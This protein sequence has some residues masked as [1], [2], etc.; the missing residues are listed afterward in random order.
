MSGLNEQNARVQLK[1]TTLSGDTPTIAPSTDHTDGNWNATDIYVGE[2]MINAATDAMWFRSLNGII[3]ITSGTTYIDNTA[4]VNKS[5]GTM[6]GGLITPSLSATSISATTIYSPS[7]NGTFIG[8]GSG[9]TGITSTIFTGGTISGPTTFTSDVDLCGAAVTVETL[10]GCGGTLSIISD[11]EVFG[12]ISATTF[13]G[14]AAGLTDLPSLSGITLDEVLTQGDTSANGNIQLTNGDITLDNGVFY[15]DGSGL[16]NIPSSPTPTLDAVLAAGNVSDDYDILLTNGNIVLGNGIFYG[17][18]SGL[19]NIGAASDIYVTG[20]TYDNS[21]GTA[22]FS[23]TSGGTFQVTGF[24]TGS[25]S[26]FTGYTYIQED[27][28]LQSLAL[29]GAST[30]IFDIEDFNYKNY[31]QRDSNLLNSQ[32]EDK[33]NGDTTN[34]TQG[35]G[36]GD[37]G[38]TLNSATTGGTLGNIEVT[39][40]LIETRV[41]DGTDTSIVSVQSNNINLSNESITSNFE[42]TLDVGSTGYGDGSIVSTTT[43][44]STGTFST[45]AQLTDRREYINIV[46]DGVGDVFRIQIEEQPGDV[47]SYTFKNDNTGDQYNK[48]VNSLSSSEEIGNG[49]IKDTISIDPS[50]LSLGTGIVSE[51]TSTND[52]SSIGINPTL[53][54]LKTE[55]DLEDRLIL[56]TQSDTNIVRSITIPSDA[57]TYYLE[58]SNIFQNETIITNSEYTLIETKNAIDPKHEVRITQPNI[59]DTQSFRQQFVNYIHD[60]VTD[61]VNLSYSEI[62]VESIYHNVQGGEGQQ[63]YIQINNGGV[64]LS[65]VEGSSYTDFIVNND[66]GFYQSQFQSTGISKG[67]SKVNYRSV[68]TTDD[69]I[70]SVVYPLSDLEIETGAIGVKATVTALNIDEDTAYVAELYAAVRINSYAP[71]IFGGVDKLEKTEFTT[72]TATIEIESSNLA[73]RVTGEAA[74]TIKWSVKYELIYS[75]N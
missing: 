21:T 16:T 64:K 67:V 29:S 14:S 28:S 26:S 13:Y 11:L 6:T 72:A 1:Y 27:V 39:N 3:P 10:S 18:G 34:I 43:D 5:G 46:D 32:I 19:T 42:T 56:Q 74:T 55:S 62:T 25:T 4:Y 69:T 40:S 33:L 38:I 57:N 60:E 53:I 9:L 70:T 61:G 30:I 7:F 24:T 35:F 8:D 22:T 47:Y 36:V 59:D 54:E 2:V 45:S 37:A 52:K 12:A 49:S 41:T 66:N 65:E 73:I 58:T 63:D 68:Q 31:T 75:V 50:V 15:G 17:D 71:T 44:T 23:N 20:G 51:N 48:Q